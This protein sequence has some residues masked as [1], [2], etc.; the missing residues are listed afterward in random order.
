MKNLKFYKKRWFSILLIFICPFIN[1][2]YIHKGISN[3]FIKII[4][5]TI[6]FLWTCFWLLF[7]IVA[8]NPN[9]YNK[10]IPNKTISG[11]PSNS[12]SHSI[13]VPI[14]HR[15]YTK[16]TRYTNPKKHIQSLKYTKPIQ[17]IQELHYNKPAKHTQQLNYNKPVQHTQ[18]LQNIQP[19]QQTNNTSNQSSAPVLNYN[20][21]SENSGNTYN[22]SHLHRHL[23]HIINKAKHRF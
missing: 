8:V 1:F 6:L 13:I 15:K 10:H 17:P 4:L 23:S 11:M 22:N 2:I 7:V 3:L 21:Q 12:A 5:N 16:H 18:A 14:R 19:V 20:I 9:T